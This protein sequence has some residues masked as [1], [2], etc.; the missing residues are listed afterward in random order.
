MVAVTHLQALH[1]FTVV[2]SCDI[3]QSMSLGFETG[4]TY[5][6]DLDDD[7]SDIVGGR[8]FENTNDGGS[9]IEIPVFVRL[10]IAF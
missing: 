7:D 8:S 9:Y 3:A 4:L 10:N 1:F 5:N 2:S 6:G